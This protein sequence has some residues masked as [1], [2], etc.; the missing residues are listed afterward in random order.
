[1]DAF[2]YYRVTG[3]LHKDNL[4]AADKAASLFI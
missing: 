3:P 1:M 2:G 4:K